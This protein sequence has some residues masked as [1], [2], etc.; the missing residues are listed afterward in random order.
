MPT[1]TVLTNAGIN[2]ASNA[3]NSGVLIAIKYCVPIYD[4]RLDAN[5]HN[6]DPTF[7]TAAITYDSTIAAT[8]ALTIPTG[9]KLWFNTPYNL[10][11]RMIL[12]GSSTVAVSGATY[13]KISN[14]PQSVVGLGVNTL[15][16][17]PLSNSIS[18]TTF[19][20]PSQTNYWLIDR[21]TSASVVGVN[22][23]T[24]TDRSKYWS[25]GDYF[26]TVNSNGD[27]VGSFRAHLN[28]TV[29]RFKFNKVAFYAVA[30]DTFG[31]ENLGVA[32]TFF[33][34]C[35]VSELAVKSNIEGDGFDDFVIDGQIS[36]RPLN[37]YGTSGFF[38]TS[39][40][41]WVRTVGGLYS[42]DPIGVGSFV[43]G[44][45]SPQSTVHV[46]YVESNQRKEN[47]LR[48]DASGATGDT[49]YITGNVNQNGDLTLSASMG[50]RTLSANMSLAPIVDSTF[51]IGT[52]IQ[53]YEEGYIN[54]VYANDLVRTPYIYTSV[55]NLTVGSPI[56]MEEEEYKIQSRD[57]L[58]VVHNQ[59]DLG[60]PSLWYAEAYI[61]TISAN[62]VHAFN[63]LDVPYIYN[64]QGQVTAFGTNIFMDDEH[65]I[66][67]CDIVPYESNTFDL[68]DPTLWYAEAYIYN[69]S[70]ININATDMY[71]NNFDITNNLTCAYIYGQTAYINFGNHIRM[72]N[73]SSSTIYS[74]DIVPLNNN[75]NKLGEPSNWFGQAYITNV[76]ATNL[77][78]QSARIDTLDCSVIE[79][80]MDGYIFFGD[81][82]NMGS[83]KKII[84]NNIV[85]YFPDVYDIGEFNN[86]YGRAYIRNISATS[87]SATNIE[88][89]AQVKGQI[90]S[91]SNSM[92]CT[93]LIKGDQVS[94]TNMTPYYMSSDYLDTY[95]FA[96]QR[97]IG[98][99]AS[100][101]L[102]INPSY[103]YFLIP[104]TSAG[105]TLRSMSCDGRNLGEEIVLSFYNRSGSSF[106]MIDEH[107]SPPTDYASFKLMSSPPSLGNT[108][109][110]II[111]FILD[112]D[113][114]I[115]IPL[116]TKYW[117]EKSRTIIDQ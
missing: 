65:K 92:V 50:F 85:P 93:G 96:R 60:D 97:I 81:D 79:N 74:E 108:Q 26:P 55:G 43:G 47:L 1:N 77:Y 82:I 18:A 78:S 105:T 21:A 61:D 30:V 73:G 83:G 22:P 75:F 52:S 11:N 68:G 72:D 109:I 59:Y 3:F 67:S 49:K 76:S 116:G 80:T 12:S 42:P 86:W 6:G 5:I 44:V 63:N 23:Q 7:G 54:S 36:L 111:T 99:I 113:Y 19:Y 94:A 90:V 45:S 103:N 69:L 87:I 84:S 16:G 95:R 14:N 70:A 41:Y 66:I 102:S 35:F 31:N 88:A 27:V 24:Y 101:H 37:A 64:S 39:G 98:S 28:Q 8:S 53:R 107:P 58:P 91:A 62:N 15:S 9:E 33:A 34:E 40:D 112:T 48:F 89:S 13:A 100:T 2:F 10:S 29:G 4:Y 32:P 57:I 46:R 114:Y 17:A 38:S 51:N 104:I 56:I 117:Y 115:T 20:A 71:A 25:V 110:L 106:G